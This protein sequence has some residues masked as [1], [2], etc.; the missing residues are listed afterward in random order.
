MDFRVNFP[1]YFGLERL[2]IKIYVLFLFSCG[3]LTPQTDVCTHST[4]KRLDFRAT[5]PDEVY[6]K[7]SAV[8]CS[9]KIAACKHLLVTED[10]EISRAREMR[11]NLLGS[12][13]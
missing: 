8:I 9:L 3:K 2:P 12:Y 1:F 4:N 11:I 6:L 13:G 10:G 5:S 7:D